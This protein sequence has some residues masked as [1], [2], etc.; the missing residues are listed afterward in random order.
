MRAAV[1]QPH[2][3]ENGKTPV[4]ARAGCFRVS[5]G[6]ALDRTLAAALVL[7]AFA[8]DLHLL[9][10]ISI[11]FDESFT[12]AEIAQPFARLWRDIT[13]WTPNMGLYYLLL[14]AWVH[15]AAALGF[16]A[17]EGVLRL[18][19]AVFAALAVGVVYAFGRRFWG[20]TVGLLAA[21]LYA[22]NPMQL[23][24]AQQAR[25]YSLEALLVCAAW[26][27]LLAA[28]TAPH[29]AP[30]RRRWWACYALAVALGMYA[31]VLSGLFVAAQLAAVVCLL[32]V[33]GPWRER[34]RA[35]RRELAVSLAA[36]LVLALPIL[37]IGRAGGTNGW[38][39]PVGIGNLASLAF[40]SIAGGSLAYLAVIAVV[41]A[42]CALCLLSA[43]LVLPSVPE[44]RS[45]PAIERLQ[46]AFGV[47]PVLGRGGGET[48][49]IPPSA[50]VLLCWLL[51]PVALAFVL[52]QPALNL[53]LFVDRY[54]AA[55]VP[56]VCLLAALGV[57]SV[58]RLPAKVVLV[59]ALVAVALP[60]VPAY[61]AQADTASFRAAASWIEAR[62]QPG[63]GIACYPTYWCAY[64]MRYE[65][66]TAGGPA[67]LDAD[68]PSDRLD[69]HT[70]ADYAAHHAR[71]FVILVTF[72][73]NPSPPTSASAPPVDSLRQYA[74]AHYR[75]LGQM[76]AFRTNY[77][78]IA[79]QMLTG[80]QVRLYATGG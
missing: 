2:S 65:L 56:A 37:Y 46:R 40:E 51:V 28:L 32:W 5:E 10:T 26:Y 77:Q 63:D 15:V 33:P 11:W 66:Q 16:A 59:A 60:L 55:V 49:A 13:T 38:V 71:V 50:F 75:L 80:V 31:H 53:H 58:Q 1:P 47:G 36:A 27:A 54:L 22:A 62:Y 48:A 30:V 24:Y 44:L 20:R 78:F 61:Y 43:L 76:A 69:A 14:Y 29:D 35:A 64:P 18:P 23:F 17:R 67:H 8:L 39:D 34:A 52:T 7:A 72:D 73:P 6:P 45:L 57:A 3:S 41:A 68:S 12:Y 74:D 25:G 21:A 42:L 4:P 79:R 19:S 70:L 9:G